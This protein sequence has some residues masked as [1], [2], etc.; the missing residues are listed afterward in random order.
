MKIIKRIP[1]LLILLLC[2]Q[3]HSD[4]PKLRDSDGNFSSNPYWISCTGNDFTLIIEPDQKVGKYSIDWGDGSPIT[5]GDSI[6]PP[7]TVEHTYSATVDT[8]VVDFTEV[9]SGCTV[10]GVVVMEEEVNASIQ[11][12][13]GTSVKQCA[14]AT[15]EF[16][17]SSTNVSETTEFTWDFGD[18]SPLLNF[19][20]TNAGDTVSHTYQPNTVDCKTAVTLKAENYCTTSPTTATFDPVKVFD[21]DEAAIK[22][23]EELLCYP[24]TAVHYGNNTDKNCVD[25]GNTAQRYEK[26]NFGDYWGKGSDSIIDWK[27]YDP[28][29]RSGY[30]IEYPGKGTY[31]VTMMDSNMCGI[32]TAKKTIEIKDPPTSNFS[33]DEDTVC[34]GDTITFTNNSSGGANSFNWNYGDGTG[35]TT[36]DSTPQTHTYSDSGDYTVTM[37]ANIANGSPSCSDTSTKNIHILPSPVAD[38][39]PDTTRGCNSLQVTYNDTSKRAV[40]WDWDFGNGNTSSVE[41]P[42][43]Q[44]YNDTGIY[45]VSLKVTA[46]NSCTN[47]KDSSIRVFDEPIASFIPDTGCKGQAVDFVN[48]STSDSNDVITQWT[49]DFEDGDSSS[50][51]NPSHTFNDT[52]TYNVDMHIM[53]SGGCTDKDSMDVE[54]SPSAISSFSVDKNSGCTPLNINFTNNSTD[55]TSYEWSFGD[56]VI[57]TQT[58]PSHEYTNNSNSDTTYTVELIAKP[59][60]GC[61]DTSTK[62]ITV[63]PAIEAKFTHDGGDDCAPMTVNFNNQ[64]SGGA[65][66]DW[67]FGDGNGSTDSDPTHTYQNNT[68]FIEVNTVTFIVTSSNGCKDTTTDDISVY[69][70]PNYDFSADPTSGCSELEVSFTS[71][72][73]A[74]SYDWDFDDGDTSDAANPTHIFTNNT[75][76]DKNFNVQMVATSAFDCKDTAT[77]TVTVKPKPNAQ[78]KLDTSQG[79][80]DLTVSIN[81]LSTGASNFELDYGNGNSSTNSSGQHSHTYQ[82]SSTSNSESYNLQLIAISSDGCKDTTEQAVNVFHDV[83]ADFTTSE[84][85]GCTPLDVDFTDQSQGSDSYSWDFDDGNTD[86]APSPGHTFNNPTNSTKNYNV[87]LTVTS[88]DGCTDNK[89]K[90]ITVYPEVT[91]QFNPDT[92]KGCHPV[93]VTFTNNSVNADKYD[94]DYDDGESSNT[95][96]STHEHTFTNTGNADSVYNVKLLAESNQGCKDSAFNQ[97]RV[98][99]DPVVKIVSDT[100]GCTPLEIAFNQQSSNVDSYFWDFD[101]STTSNSSSPT[102]IFTNSGSLDSTYNVMLEGTS[103]KGCTDTA[104]KNILVH[105]LPVAD[106]TATP[107]SQMYPN[108]VV[109]VTNNNNTGS[110]SYVWDWDDGKYDS[111]ATPGSHDYSTWGDYTIRLTVFNQFCSDTKEQDI[112]IIPPDPIAAFSGAKKGCKPLSVKFFN[113]SEWETSYKWEFGDGSTSSIEN[114]VHTYSAPGIYDVKLKVKGPGGK[115]SVTKEEAVTVSNRANAQ[116]SFDPELVFVPNQKVEF[117]NFSRNANNFQWFFGDSS[118]SDEVEPEHFYQKTGLYTVALIANNEHNCPDTMVQKSAITAQADGNIEFPDAFTPLKVKVDGHYDPEAINNNIFH[119]VHDGVDKYHLTIYNRWGELVFESFDVNFGWNGFYKGKP[120]QQDVYVWKVEGRFLD[121]REFRKKGEVTLLR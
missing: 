64:S 55:A 97:I 53:T 79:C 87:E 112:T 52:G 98:Y 110:W 58:N 9:D 40:A 6:V 7:N 67:D 33:A 76:N 104:F 59:N 38:F 14:P 75:T 120:A 61:I 12:P 43:T 27:P 95:T 91:A 85:Q 32:D 72:I 62:G 35:W 101:D 108:S 63:S 111:T 42:P 102:H 25:E 88:N 84:T 77:H 73:G 81:N 71:E 17:N 92:T 68:Q 44:S 2:H 8:F 24:D 57:S 99:P 96:V 93:N 13:S 21:K 5:T 107:L 39:I 1:V 109:N 106:F 105:P 113:E 16:I 46:S 121:G 56:G 80:P 47:S 119:P 83:K 10:Q 70:E 69:P 82:N 94:W 118:G 90:S 65:S 41:D 114:P 51:E 103:S 3:A 28:P 31:T 30:T 49:W 15:M 11:I 20:H 18:G 116:F 45:E 23:S 50:Q 89:S 29:S 22:A 34:I 74:V 54:I 26:W 36:T 100:E 19:D 66:F 78:F 86:A 117:F 4:C 60:K 48:Q 115:D 37:V